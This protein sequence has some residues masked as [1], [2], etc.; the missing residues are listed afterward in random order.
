MTTKA[1]KYY[2]FTGVSGVHF[3]ASLLSFLKLHAVPTTRN[4]A[5]PDVLVC[6]DDGSRSLTLSVKTSHSAE[7]WSGRTEK[8]LDHLEWEIGPGAVGRSSHNLWY[9]LVDLQK[10]EKLP[11]VYF[12]PSKVVADFCER[13]LAERFGGKLVNWKRVRWHPKIDK[14]AQYKNKDGWEKFLQALK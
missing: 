5:G 6:N 9:A 11:D 12:V 3:V 13:E 10:F 4:I 2:G 8:R 14:V 7:R 1:K